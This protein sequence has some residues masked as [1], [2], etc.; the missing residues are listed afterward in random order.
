MAR[1]RSERYKGRK[2]TMTDATVAFDADGEAIGIVARGSEQYDAPLP[3]DEGVV[4]KARR[5]PDRFQVIEDE[6]TPDRADFDL[7]T[8]RKADLV[9]VAEELGIED[10]DAMTVAELREAISAG[11]ED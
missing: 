7:S 1:I 5:M 10:A 3:L 9:T 6:A 4:E 2:V 11:L 8:A